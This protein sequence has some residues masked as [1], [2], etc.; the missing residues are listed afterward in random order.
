MNDFDN[1]FVLQLFHLTDQEANTTTVELAPNLSAIKNV[2]EAQ[3][4]DG[5]GEAGY[6]HTISLSSGDVWIPGLFYN[7]SEDIYGALG[8]ADILIQNELGIDA[9]S[10]G[11]HEFDQGP[12]VIADLLDP[13]RITTPDG[14]LPYEGPNFPYLGGNL[15]FSADEDLGPLV[16][17]DGQEASDIAGRIAGTTVVTTD[18]GE[19]IGIVS[20]VTPELDNGLTSPG[21]DILVLPEGVATASTPAEFDAIAAVIQEDVDALLAANPD[22]NKVILLSHMQQITIEQA[23]ATRLEGVDIIVGGGSNRVFLDENDLG[24]GGE[25]PFTTYPEE[26]TGADGDPVL[27]VN[28]DRSYQ[29]LGRLVIDFDE[30]GVIIPGSYDAD[31]SG[32]YATDDAGLANV[33]ATA[34]DADPEIQAIADLVGQNIV[35]GESD[36]FAVTEFFLNAQRFSNPGEK[37]DGVRSQE[38]N[39]AN[40]IALSHLDAAQDADPTTQ[41]AYIN[42]GGIRA[43]IGDIVAP[44]GGGDPIRIPPEGVPGAK[45]EGGISANQVLDVVAFNNELEIVTITGEQLLQVVE[46]GVSGFTAVD[47]EAD[48]F[49]HY[50][51]LDFSFDPS[52]PVGDRVVNAVIVDEDTGEIVQQLVKNGETLP[53][54]AEQ[55]FKVV[56]LN[57]LNGIGD[58]V[59]SALSDEEKQTF[60]L[61]EDGQ[62][63]IG[64]TDT[65]IDG[66][67]QDAF[68]EWLLDTFGNEDGAPTIQAFD[69]EV[70]QDANIQNLAF[71]PDTV[72]DDDALTA[73]LVTVFQGESDP[74]DEDSPEGASEVVAQEAGALFVTNGNL[75]RVDIFNIETGALTT[76]DLTTLPDY[77]GVQSLAVSNGL[78]AVAVDNTPVDGE[79]V[80]GQV[81]FYDTET[82]ELVETVTVGNLPDQVVFSP[83]GSTLAVMNEGEFNSESDVTNDAPG[84]ISLIDTTTFEETRILVSSG[85]D[86]IN[87]VEGLRIDPNLDPLNQ[88]EPEYGS[89]IDNNTLAVAAQ[90]NNLALVIDAAAAEIVDA[91]SFGTVDHSVTGNEFDFND[92]DIIEIVNADVEGLR[93]PDGHVPFVIDGVPYL[94][95]ANEGDGRG[96][97]FDFDGDVPVVIP[98]GDEARVS[99]IIEAAEAGIHPGFDPSVDTT[100]LERLIVSTVDGDTD[101]D[102]DIDQITSFGGRGFTIF[103]LA[104]G[105]VAFEAG[106]DLELIVADLA[107]ERFLDDDGEDG[108]NRADAKGV[109]PEAIEFGEVGGVPYLFVGAERDSG[110]FVFDVTDPTDAKFV[111]YIDGFAND[112]VGPEIITF[113]SEDESL[114]GRAQIAVS[115]EITGETAIFDLTEAAINEEVNDLYQIAFGRDA[116]QDGFQFWIGTEN[117]LDT[118]DRAEFFAASGEFASAIDGLDTSEAVDYLFN[119]ASGEAASDS[120]N[121]FWTDV[122]EDLGFA[123]VIEALTAIDDPISFA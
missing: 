17:A 54:V 67:Q 46:G 72:A 5:D 48:G 121:A 59:L 83:D 117:S 51:G 64:G 36:F 6:V 101:G 107:P 119:N 100:G 70:Q 105:E 60:N 95:T 112:L 2:L 82:L 99:E 41:I 109:E 114:T 122:A 4:I 47:A 55:E 77:D 44:G 30:D 102:G 108:Q 14:G 81:A 66:A 115:Y 31:I 110:I 78:L 38:T 7:A 75:D 120:L 26:Y 104:T 63:Y 25:D 88:I 56:T 15:D 94:A 90:E 97:A 87:A 43:N 23:L 57:F 10:F 111:E 92:D 20:A 37:I 123:V 73:E 61:V 53:G 8:A 85:A 116:D 62:E 96:D 45:P 65:F 89:W 42:G 86:L 76:I 58:P 91:F 39:L 118:R 27:L 52:L 50:A 3:D 11:N 21:D 32:G 12:G 113:I 98:N 106:S 1:N 68:A 29:Y 16:T 28:T 40:L 84:S 18:G 74:E 69:T 22:I 33:G 79:S 103:N 80:E 35:E 34:A 13:S 93:Q 19:R 9:I 49:A 24:F 71:R